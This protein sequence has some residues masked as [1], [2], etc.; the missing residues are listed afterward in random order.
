MPTLLQRL[1]P[2]PNFFSLCLT[3]LKHYF[4]QASRWNVVSDSL[5]NKMGSKFQLN[6]CKLGDLRQVTSSLWICFSIDKMSTIWAHAHKDCWVLNEM[7]QAKCWSVECAVTVSHQ[8][9]YLS[10]GKF[11]EV[12]RARTMISILKWTNQGPEWWIDLLKAAQD[13]QPSKRSHSV[14]WVQSLQTSAQHLEIKSWEGRCWW[15]GATQLGHCL[16]V[17]GRRAS[18]SWLQFSEPQ[19]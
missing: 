1:Q 7:M 12:S 19:H 11:C 13:K 4:H 15:V 3:F 10:T 2:A 16:S 17:L 6:L 14:P 9:Y 8:Y 18:P 5:V